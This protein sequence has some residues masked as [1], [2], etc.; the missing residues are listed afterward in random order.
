MAIHGSA[1]SLIEDYVG[2]RRTGLRVARAG[3]QV[4]RPLLLESHA[5]PLRRCENENDRPTDFRVVNATLSPARNR[6]S[7]QLASISC[8]GGGRRTARRVGSQLYHSY[9]RERYGASHEKEQLLRSDW[10]IP[11]NPRLQCY[12][13]Y[14]LTSKDRKVASRI[15]RCDQHAMVE[16]NGSSAQLAIAWL[17]AALRVACIYHEN[18][19][20]MTCMRTK[21]SGQAL[22]ALKQG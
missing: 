13:N 14:M 18:K 9:H 20:K 12:E 5:C 3:A 10:Q 17:H 2:K 11:L 19:Q 21:I 7:A 4:P 8:G 6:T 16:R 1:A 22:P 15:C